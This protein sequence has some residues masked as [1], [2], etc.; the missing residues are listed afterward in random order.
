MIILVILILVGVCIGLYFLNKRY[1]IFGNVMQSKP[2]T[3]EQLKKE[4]A[5]I[6]KLAD[7]FEERANYIEAIRQSK[8]KIA[9]AKAKISPS[10]RK[11]N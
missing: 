4:A 9:K 2:K 3:L 8:D 7:E 11:P 5:E 6:K 1:K 10:G